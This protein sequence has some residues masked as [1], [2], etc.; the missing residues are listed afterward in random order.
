M[1]RSLFFLISVFAA[2]TAFASASGEE[3]SKGM[4]ITL[5]QALDIAF[6]NNPRL[7][8]A[9]YQVEAAAAGVVKAGSGNLPKIEINEIYQRTTNPM[10]AFGHKLNQESISSADFAPGSLNNPDPIDNWGTTLTLS[11]TVYSGGKV[12]AYK[13]QATLA[14]EAS[15]K[16][17][18]RIMQEVIFEVTKAYYGITLGESN[19]DT[20]RDALKSADVNMKMAQAQRDAGVILESDFLS[21]RVTWA[22]L[23]EEEI[24]ALNAVQLSKAALNNVMGVDLEADYSPSERLTDGL[25]KI[26]PE[27]DHIHE[28]A[29]QGDPTTARSD[30]AGM[31]LREEI[32]EKAVKVVQADLLPTIG[33]TANYEIDGSSPAGDDGANW[34]VMGVLKWNLFSG[35]E[36]TARVSEARAE[37]NRVKEMR[38]EM[39][40]GIRLEALSARLELKAARERVYVATVSVKQAEEG[41]R[42]VKN[43]YNE[44]MTTTVDLLATETALKKAK[45]SLSRALYDYKIGESRLKLALGILK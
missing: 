11:Q 33:L 43:R 37:S 38:R 34:T 7:K 15:L 2:L 32:G 18:E 14:K 23:K 40:N 35:Y 30:L 6:S 45:Q 39:E 41:F 13:E 9:G 16:D 4:P 25:E 42:I 22:G 20:V 27:Y 12:T 3:G 19:L 24:K 36:D 1:L 21:A 31:K 28:G 26:G 10:W 17:K 8:S 5:E 44:G 29:K